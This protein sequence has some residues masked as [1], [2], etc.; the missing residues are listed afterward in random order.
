MVLKNK[1]F[2]Y[3]LIH[4]TNQY[5]DIL[6]QLVSNYNSNIHSTTKHKPT[7]IKF[8]S[9]ELNPLV[10]ENITKVAQ[11]LL[12]HKPQNLKRMIQFELQFEVL[13]NINEMHLV[14]RK[15]HIVEIYSK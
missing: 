5:I 3:F 4:N 9:N 14:N 2:N 10:K 8:K 6:P 11:N 7:D 1:I 12:N 13:I 15:K